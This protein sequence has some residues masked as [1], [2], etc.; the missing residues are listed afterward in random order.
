MDTDVVVIGA[1]IA[2]LRAARRLEEHGRSVVV[3]EAEGEVGG[4]IRTDDVSGFLCDRGFQ[5]LNP[6]YPALREAVDLEALALHSFGVGAIIR[7]GERATTLAHPLRHPRFALQTLLSEHVPIRDVLALARWLGPTLVGLDGVGPEDRALRASLD[8]AGL[9]GKLRHDL[10]DTFLAGVLADSSGESSA[11]FVKQLVRF[12]ALGA[13][14]LPRAG[15]RALPAQMASS[16][17]EPVRL[18]TAAREVNE[19]SAGVRVVTDR[20]T[21]LARAA[22][23]AVAPRELPELTGEAAP[24]THGLTTW[25]FRASG[26]PRTGPYLVIDASLPGGGPAGPIWNTAVIS[27]VAPSYAPAGQHLVQATTLLDRIDGLASEAQIRDDLAR[28]YGTSTSGWE[29]LAHHVVPHALPAVLPPFRSPGPGQVGER[30]LVTG[31]HRESSSIQ[32]ALVAGQR[33]ADAACTMLA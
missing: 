29:V 8:E 24:A 9:T 20:G 1:G 16:L 10:L 4:R 26:E 14:G 13:P 25:W 21:I 2:G 11:N 27:E 7:S 5:V 15:M 6:A 31:D 33:A 18:E 32:G 28:L 22:I 12:F 3:V 30:V 17:H 23:V 19:T